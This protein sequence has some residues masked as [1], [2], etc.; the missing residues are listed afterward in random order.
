MTMEEFLADLEEVEAAEAKAVCALL[1]YRLDATPAREATWLDGNQA[2][3]EVFG[4][5]ANA[6]IWAGFSEALH[7]L[8][9]AVSERESRRV[10]ASLTRTETDEAALEAAREAVTR[11][12]RIAT[13]TVW[14][15]DAGE[16]GDEK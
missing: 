10:M 15:G 12:R 2:A 16:E 14:A 3:R 13:K 6:W 1:A 8:C 4:R 11:A 5:V 9:H 7:A